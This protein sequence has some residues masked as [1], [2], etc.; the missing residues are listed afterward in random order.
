MASYC[1][2]DHR[3]TRPM[4]AL[5]NTGR[6]SWRETKR[7]IRTNEEKDRVRQIATRRPGEMRE[8]EKREKEREWLLGIYIRHPFCTPVLHSL[9]FTFRCLHP[10]T[11]IHKRACAFARTHRHRCVQRVSRA[12]TRVAAFLR[13]PRATRGGGVHHHGARESA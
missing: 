9:F 5:S 2:S 3:R 4:R 7:A 8:K 13:Y 11:N 12:L 10:C 1:T 6:H